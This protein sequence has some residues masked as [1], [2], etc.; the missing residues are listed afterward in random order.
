MRRPIALSLLS[1]AIILAQTAE[2][3]VV[4]TIPEYTVQELGGLHYITLTGGEQLMIEGEPLLPFYPATISFSKGCYI[5]NVELIDKSG[6][7]LRTGIRLPQ[8][9]ITL[10]TTDTPG[11]PV[12]ARTD[13]FYPGKDFD[14]SVWA[15]R[16]GGTD[17]VISIYPFQF[18][19]QT[20]ELVF[21]KNFRFR[22]H[23]ARTGITSRGLQADQP[24]FGLG[25]RVS[26]HLNLTN[27][28]QA[29]DITVATAVTGAVNTELGERRFRIL[30]GDT[31]LLIDWQ[32]AAGTYG[33]CQ[34]C[35]RVLDNT[36][37]TI[38]T[39]CTPIRLG[40]PE[41]ELIDFSAQPQFFRI[42][43]TVRFSLQLRN[44][45][46]WPLSGSCTF[47][48]LKGN[49]VIF[50]TLCPYSGLTPGSTAT[51]NARWHTARATQSALYHALAYASFAGTTTSHSSLELSTDRPPQPLF[52]PV[53]AEPRAGEPVE[54]DA[55]GSTDPD[56]TIAEYRWDFG[57]GG[58][59]TGVRTRHTF[60]LPGSYLVTLTAIDNEGRQAT[61]TRT[62]TAG[63]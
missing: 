2:S 59:G 34:V 25:E 22:V 13:G 50:D 53:P 12:A 33:D 56:G 44:T 8:V 30:S 52:E 1:A 55:S 20:T 10:D 57:D 48:I 58:T 29:Q 19:S 24:V 5:Q 23:Y 7:E 11:A 45:G 27:T 26:L 21:H 47:R 40:N 6:R 37:S 51:V 9:V 39:E 38:L 54:F 63:D 4:V 42:G 31:S 43:D 46:S 49:A 60:Q 15:N 61:L 17:L 28:G 35:T 32:P 3:L 18:N 62:V 16:R 36:N 41:L 14:W